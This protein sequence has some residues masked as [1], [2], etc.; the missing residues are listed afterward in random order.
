MPSLNMN[1][2][3]KSIDVVL[4]NITAE[5]DEYKYTVN[6]TQYLIP[7]RC[8]KVLTVTAK[9]VKVKEVNDM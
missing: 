3:N 1:F 9:I 6:L 4:H 2:D 7:S 8:E 5:T